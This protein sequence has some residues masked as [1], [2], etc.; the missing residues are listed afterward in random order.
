MTAILIA[1]DEASILDC[2]DWALKTGGFTVYR[3]GSGKE[4]LEIFAS[5]RPDLAILDIKMPPPDGLEVL[6]EIRKTSKMP[7]IFLTSRVEEVDRI[8]GLEVGADDYVTK[9][10]SPRELAARVKA[11]LRRLTPD[12]QSGGGAGI[13][14]YG[15]LRLDEG[16]YMLY[17]RGKPVPVGRQEFNILRTLMH[18]PGMVFTRNSLLDKAW[19]AESAVTDRVVDTHI[20]RI[21]QKIREADPKLEILETVHGVG[22]R[23]KEL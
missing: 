8:V 11:I 23:M 10:F 4:A 21:R 18:R 19:G 5:K 22:Y 14:E 13:V 12:D 7:V 1:D 3:A 20:K 16:R 15:P 2:V 17:V 6:K 9:P